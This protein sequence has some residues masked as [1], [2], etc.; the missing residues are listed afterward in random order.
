M[1]FKASSCSEVAIPKNFEAVRVTLGSTNGRQLVFS[2]T[3]DAVA[4]GAFMSGGVVFFTHIAGFSTEAVGAAFSLQ[5]VGGL[6]GTLFLGPVADLFG[7]KRILVLMLT[8]QAVIFCIYPF[9]HQAWFFFPLLFLFGCAQYGGGPAFGA[10]INTSFGVKARVPVRSV[11]RTAFNLGFSLGTGV[12][13]LAISLGR[14]ELRMLPFIAGLS[15]LIS[16]GLSSML[17]AVSGA[18]TMRRR[19]FGAIRDKRFLAIVA[20]NFPLSL[21]STILLVA[22]PLVMLHVHGLPDWAVPLTIIVNTVL[23]IALQIPASRGAET[24][25]G[26]ARVGRSSGLWLAAACTLLFVLGLGFT[27]I[28]LSLTITGVIVVLL[29]LSELRQSAASWGMAHELAPRE[30]TAEYIGTFNL[31]SVLQGVF[32]PL[33][34]VAILGYLGP[35][36]W[37]AIIILVIAASALLP[38]TVRRFMKHQSTVVQP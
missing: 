13:F 2:H 25:L 38:A 32:G 9:L 3:A 36:A 27:D 12:A 4:K 5:A 11:L 23:A 35:W 21:H 34:M 8:V 33:F 28:L 17:S 7:A 10:L 24:P 14:W 30:A 26:A 6:V 19:L 1:R 29:T 22:L 15:M 31:Y 18:S 37:W 16:A 20:T